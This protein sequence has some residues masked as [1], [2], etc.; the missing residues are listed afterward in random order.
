MPDGLRNLIRMIDFLWMDGSV[1]TYRLDK[2][3]KNEIIGLNYEI[4]LWMWWYGWTD[5]GR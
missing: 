2:N 1:T 3:G 5:Y 4:Y